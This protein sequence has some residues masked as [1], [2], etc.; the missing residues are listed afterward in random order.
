[1]RMT[2]I[3]NHLRYAIFGLAALAS[4]AFIYQSMSQVYS[5]FDVSAQELTRMLRYA[6]KIETEFSLFLNL[7]DRFGSGDAVVSRAE[8]E[9]AFGRLSDR[10]TKLAAGIEVAGE[11]GAAMRPDLSAAEFA[12]TSVARQIKSL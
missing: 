3:A 1:M 6:Q 10:V 8:L 12:L 5:A 7:L 9:T 2:R 11:E 4:A